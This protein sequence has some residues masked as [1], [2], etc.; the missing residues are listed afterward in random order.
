MATV[1]QTA[2]IVAGKSPKV[3]PE[4]FVITAYSYFL[5]STAFVVNDTV[6]L[7]TLEANPSITY[8]GPTISTVK[9]AM[10]PM[11]SSTG[12]TWVVG[13]SGSA[14]RYITTQTLGQSGAGGYASTTSTQYA[15]VG[16]QPFINSFNTYTTASL[17]TYTIILKVTAAA[18]GTPTTGN[19]IVSFVDYTYDP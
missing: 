19:T 2:Q 13:D 18:T 5:N 3:L 4:G 16:Y 12:F 9:V 7:I 6:Q 14:N 11:D 10:P 15:A 8:N 17:A 1:Y